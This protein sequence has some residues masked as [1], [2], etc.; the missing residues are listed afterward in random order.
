MCSDFWASVGFRGISWPPAT[1]VLGSMASSL[2]VR[3][4]PVNHLLSLSFPFPLPL[5][6]R[7]GLGCTAFFAASLMR[8]RQCEPLHAAG[9][10]C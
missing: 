5:P 1:P 8:Q 10:G 2:C 9:C 3:R 6:F 7:A 4:T